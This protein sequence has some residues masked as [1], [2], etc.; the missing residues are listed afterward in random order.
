MDLKAAF[1]KYGQAQGMDEDQIEAITE[2]GE[3]VH[4]VV[5]STITTTCAACKIMPL[6]DRA[7]LLVFLRLPNFLKAHPVETLYA[8]PDEWL[9]ELALWVR[10]VIQDDIRPQEDDNA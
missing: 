1:I 7:S 10:D 3:I 8:T 4:E 6:K 9:R 2:I 5:T